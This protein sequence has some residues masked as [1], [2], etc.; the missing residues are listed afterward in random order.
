[1]GKKKNNSRAGVIVV[2][3]EIDA[4]TVFLVIRNTGKLPVLNL[5][6]KPSAVILGLEGKRDIGKLSI[7]EEIS[8]LAPL[9]EIKI[10][11]DSFESFF[12][13]LKDSLVTFSIS[14]RDEKNKSLKMKITH[15]LK[16]YA[17]LIFL[18]KKS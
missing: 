7:F 17:D 18:I 6:I 11:V 5:K 13:N 3:F 9:K 2:D 1:M 14:Y 4:E 10:F 16:I 8:Y 15:D 12:S